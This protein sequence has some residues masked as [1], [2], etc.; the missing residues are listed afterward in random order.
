MSTINGL[1]VITDENLITHDNLK[2]SVEQAI[3]GGASIVQYRNKS[4]DSQ[5]KVTQAENILQVCNLHS[6]P[7]I[8]NDDIALCAEIGADGVHL[9][10]DDADIADAKE[11]LGSDTII[12]ITCHSSIDL[13]VK[14][15][16]GGAD[17]V[18]FGS[19]FP[20]QTKPDAKPA[21][22]SILEKAQLMLN[23]PTV[24]IGGINIDNASQLIEAGAS[25]IAV[26]GAVFA[27]S[28][29]KAQAEKLSRLFR[30]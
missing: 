1:Y 30:E 13:A 7:L 15:Q 3:L 5:T 23:I 19:F 2:Y 20:S 4:A 17:Y 6:V 21:E 10:Q 12:G 8:I 16:E 25:S 14:A 9:G 29:P 11:H 26:A 24:A 22:I 27:G 28:D 18:A